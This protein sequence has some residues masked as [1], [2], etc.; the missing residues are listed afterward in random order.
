M[1]ACMLPI[2]VILRTIPFPEDA[3]GG[4]VPSAGIATVAL[5]M[6][7]VMGYNL[8]WGP[9]PWALVPEIFPN[10]TREMGMGICLTVHWL[11]N[12][13][14]TFSTPY[15]I[16][17]T[18]TRGWGTFLF[19][20]IFD[21]IMATWVLMFVPETKGKSL[22]RV[23]AEINHDESALHHKKLTV[24]HEQTETIPDAADSK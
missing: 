14:F 16:A 17:G 11:F 22:E 9:I 21:L 13:V 18:G 15:M 2:A 6:M 3:A 8:S 10:R 5:V 24:V 4:P 20:A 12:F 7:N 23:N 1:F 19:Y